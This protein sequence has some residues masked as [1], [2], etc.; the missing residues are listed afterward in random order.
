MQYHVGDDNS[1]MKIEEDQG[2]ESQNDD[3][4]IGGF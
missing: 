4:L 1:I 3:D 2:R